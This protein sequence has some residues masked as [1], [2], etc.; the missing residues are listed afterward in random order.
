MAK[1][2]KFFDEIINA[3]DPCPLETAINDWFDANPQITNVEVYDM[4][5]SSGFTQNG[6]V[7][8]YDDPLV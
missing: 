2:V 3:T 8:I 4:G 6:V 7:I 1:Q 5:N